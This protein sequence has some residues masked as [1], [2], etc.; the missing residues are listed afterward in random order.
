MS[1]TL[2]SCIFKALQANGTWES[3]K[4]GKEMNLS[5]LVIEQ[6]DIKMCYEM[7]KKQRTKAGQRTPTMHNIFPEQ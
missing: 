3:Y 4:T 5:Q 2:S 1:H 6:P 7:D